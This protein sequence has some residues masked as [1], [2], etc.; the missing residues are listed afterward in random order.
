MHVQQKET[1]PMDYQTDQ[2]DS[3]RSLARRVQRLITTPRARY[4]HQAVIQRLPGDQPDDWERLLDEISDAE[5]VKLNLRPD[6]SVHVV[7]YIPFG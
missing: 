6:G 2:A 3:Y 1:F 4:E 5:G 7:W